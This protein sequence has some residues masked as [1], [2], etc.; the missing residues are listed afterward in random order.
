M[1]KLSHYATLDVKGKF[2]FI[3]DI[4]GNILIFIP[5]VIA[6]SFLF[7]KKRSDKELFFL[8]LITT[9]SI[10]CLQYIFDVGVFDVDDI[11]LNLTGGV[12]GIYLFNLIHRKFIV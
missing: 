8:V 3:E 7:P 6:L 12:I 10:E 2:Y 11:A 4:V 1:D 5:F 9:I